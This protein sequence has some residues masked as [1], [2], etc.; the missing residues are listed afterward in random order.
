RAEKQFDDTGKPCR[1]FGCHVDITERKLGEKRLLEY[2]QRL[3]AL[4][5]QLTLTEE[6][7]KRHIASDLHDHIGHSLALARMQL[8]AVLE[9]ASQTERTV[10]INDISNIILKAIQDTKNLIFEL[11][12]PLMNEIGLAAA[13]SEWLEEYLERRYGLET[14]L[15]DK[16]R[17]KSLDNDL[18]A[19]LFRN[20]R[21]LFTNII[22]HSKAKKVNILLENSAVE[23]IIT[24][25][26]DGIGFDPA[27][28]SRD[29]KLEK[30]FGLFSIQERMADLNGSLEIISE[31]GKGS[32]IIM[33]VP[34]DNSNS[35]K[36]A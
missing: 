5:T 11:S 23:Y 28:V 16:S 17:D 3:K 18:R 34:F 10:L 33:S 21:E 36:K 15:I 29:V 9:A 2:Q 26:D 19:I 4:A 12:S 8:D 7:E 13:I 32:K 27:V 14:E 31:P 6:K 22:K 20:V 1:L 35:K 24:I 30:R 25:T